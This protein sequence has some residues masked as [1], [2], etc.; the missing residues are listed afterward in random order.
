MD[1]I[2]KIYAIARKEKSDFIKNKKN[3]IMMV[4]FPILLFIISIAEKQSNISSISPS[5]ITMH[6]VMVPLMCM[7]T[8]IAEEKEKNTLRMLI[9]SNVKPLEYLIGIGFIIFMFSL[10]GLGVFS[11][12]DAFGEHPNHM[13]EIYLL[14]GQICSLIIGAIIGVSV[15]NQVSVTPIALPLILTLFFIPILAQSNTMIAMFSKYLFTDAIMRMLIANKFYSDSGIIILL[16][17]LVFSIFFVVCYKNK[18]L[19][20]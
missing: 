6:I 17:I 16:N 20:Q 18:K 1:F 14:L 4:I 12:M 13:M 8:I 7:A 5:F 19:I 15:N 9:L 3:L 10:M 2:I 11:V